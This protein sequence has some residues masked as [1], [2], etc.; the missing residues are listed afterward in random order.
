MVVNSVCDNLDHPNILE[1]LYCPVL[2]TWL[3]GFLDQRVVLM[4]I[5]CCVWVILSTKWDG[6]IS[7]AV[8]F[9]IQWSFVLGS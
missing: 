9:T 4:A 7:E 1:A 6:V 5:D 8:I 3:E 2:F